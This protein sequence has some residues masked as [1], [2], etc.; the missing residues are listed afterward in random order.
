MIHHLDA[1]S[2]GKAITTWISQNVVAAIRVL[3]S[4]PKSHSVPGEKRTSFNALFKE[5]SVHG[6]QLL[7]NANQHVPGGQAVETLMINT[8]DVSSR[9]TLGETQS[10]C[11]DTADVSFR[12]E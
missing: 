6:V 2:K 7:S 4:P 9:D 8:W 5:N 11:T 3:T 10:L 12:I 1:T